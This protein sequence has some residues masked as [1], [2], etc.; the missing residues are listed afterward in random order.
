MG[1]DRIRMRGK[2][3]LI[4]GGVICAAAAAG[5]FV[6]YRKQSPPRV[7]QPAAAELPSGAEITLTGK[8]RAVHTVSLDAPVS[9]VLEE[10]A[11]A[12]GDEVYEGQILGRI[13]NDAIRE[14][15]H[16]AQL[17]LERPQA[18]VNALDAELTATRLEESRLAADAARARGEFARTERVYQR[19]TN[20]LR[21]GATPRLVYQRA[22]E[23]FAAAGRD[24]ERAESLL[25]AV[26]DRV[27]ALLKAIDA[28]RKVVSDKQAQ[29]E[30]AQAKVAS[31]NLV[32]PADGLVVSIRK[33]AGEQVEE[34]FQ[35][36][37]ELAEDWSQ[38]EL[39]VE[40][41]E[42]YTKR[43][44]PGGPVRVQLAELPGEGLEASI[45]SVEKE[46]IVIGFSSPSALVRPGTTAV[47]RFRLK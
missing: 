37:I 30:S 11:V 27:Q 21:E 12:P 46:S 34:G 47:A 14:D 20:L 8:V 26:Q 28:A 9:G 6:W 1:Y 4:M 29:L 33:A 32:A 45:K 39:L 7:V 43:L 13:A 15:E 40:A 35:G 19:Q 36:L 3:I 18:R 25:A 22:E 44:A 2:W 16:E 10:F 31:C 24:R 23:E 5:A 17:E 41:P 42:A 38:L